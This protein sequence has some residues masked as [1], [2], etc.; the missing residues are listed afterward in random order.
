MSKNYNLLAQAVRCPEREPIEVHHHQG[1]VMTTKMAELLGF[2]PALVRNG[3]FKGIDLGAVARRLWGLAAMRAEGRLPAIYWHAH[4]RRS[5]AWGMAHTA[6]RVV[7]VRL[8]EGASIEEAVETL[9]HEL[10]HCACPLRE[11]HGELFCRRLIACAREAFGL[12]LSTADLLALPASGG[13]VA[14]AIDTA[15]R[16]AMAAAGVG[17]KLRADMACRFEPPPVETDE[18][19]AARREA[20]SLARIAAREAH[21]RAKLAA[22]E[23]RAESAK[24]VASKWRAKVRYYE[25]RQDAAA[26][27]RTKEPS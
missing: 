16:D 25:R 11:H 20:A 17:D 22:W 23:K 5:G 2:Y 19:I 18:Q 9:L 7:H 24:R 10:V 1:T 3:V 12:D 6:S 13:R 14:Y 21:A 26:K 4:A 15:V 8:T 27:R